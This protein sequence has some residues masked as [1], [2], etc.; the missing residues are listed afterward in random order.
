MKAMK[1][2]KEQLKNV[3]QGLREANTGEKRDQKPTNIDF[4]LPKSWLT[5]NGSLSKRNGESKRSS[6]HAVAERQSNVSHRI[7]RQPTTPVKTIPSSDKSSASSNRTTTLSFFRPRINGVRNLVMPKWIEIGRSLQHPDRQD[8]KAAPLTVRIGVDFGTAFTKVAIRAGVDLIPIDWFAVTGDES[9]TG[10]YVMPGIV[11]LASDGEYCWRQLSE[12]DVQGN[13]K[14]P[15]IEMAG[16]DECPTAALAYLALVIRYARA[17]LYQHP[18]VGRKL[19]ARS[20]RWEL[21]VGCPTE[22]HEKPEVVRLFQRIARIAWQLAAVGSLQESNIAAAWRADEAKVGLETEPA[23]VP[24]FVAQIAGYLGSPHV[25]EGLHALIDIGAATLDVATFNV[26][27]MNE[28][29]SSPSIPIFFSA[30]HPLG[31]HYLCHNRHSRLD[32]DLAW[33]DAVPVECAD[34]FATRF[35]KHRSEIDSID[36]EFVNLIVRSITGVIDGTRTNSRGD[37]RSL[38]WREGLPIFVTGGGS[39]CE[40]YRRAIEVVQI[41]LKRRL[42]SSNRFRFI[43]LDPRGAQVAHLG[44]EIGGRLTVAMG[45]TEDAENIARVIPH[46]DIERITQSTKELVDHTEIYGDQ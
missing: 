27:L 37:P 8:E 13:L 42:G 21:N 38:A 24:E 3:K 23:V 40:I 30:V 33:D 4:E 17:F 10:R 36:E 45:L 11:V 20:L 22:P 7:V 1:S 15:V 44:V 35:G 34:E 18:D 31:T 19:V 43:E 16:S 5:D 2:W 29:D 39:G 9:P 46:R 32:L 41:E 12:S 14:L 6:G 28:L 25:S 26:V